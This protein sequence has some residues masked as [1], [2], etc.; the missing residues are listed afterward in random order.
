MYGTLRFKL[1]EEQQE[2]ET[3]VHAVSYRAAVEE[4]W[5]KLFRPRH[6]H[7]YSQSQINLL[8]DEE[9]DP[10]SAAACHA[11]MDE[12]EKLYHEVVEELPR[13]GL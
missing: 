5:Q 7:G 8:L 1:P 10:G 11:L 3:A 6:K 2:F 12:L 13:E 4:I 9:I